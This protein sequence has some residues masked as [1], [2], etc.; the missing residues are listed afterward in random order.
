MDINTYYSGPPPYL[1]D[2]DSIDLLLFSLAIEPNGRKEV[3]EYK[4]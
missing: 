4:Y 2:D 3:N 1:Q